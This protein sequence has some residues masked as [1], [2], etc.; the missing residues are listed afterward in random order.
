MVRFSISGIAYVGSMVPRHIVCIVWGL[1]MGVVTGLRRE[2]W[3]GTMDGS[4]NMSS[5]LRMAG[6]M[7]A[8]GG[9]FS[10]NPNE[11]PFSD[12]FS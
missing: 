5:R 6:P 8:Y 2:Q 3:R 10:A 7:G 9:D 12:G 1:G 4:G 11:P